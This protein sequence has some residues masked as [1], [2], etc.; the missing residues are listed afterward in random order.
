MENKFYK[1]NILDFFK[2]SVNTTLYGPKY[3]LQYNVGSETIP[4][5]MIE[6]PNNEDIYAKNTKSNYDGYFY[7]DYTDGENF[8]LRYKDES[9]KD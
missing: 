6:S 3:I 4:F 5:I 9:S 2:L 1:M 7:K 8:F